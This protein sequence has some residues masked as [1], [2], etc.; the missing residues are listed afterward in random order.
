MKPMMNKRVDEIFTDCYIAMSDNVRRDMAN[1]FD[2]VGNIGLRHKRAV[3]K[4]DPGGVYLLLK[5]GEVKP[6]K[7]QENLLTKFAHR[8][9]T[10]PVPSPTHL[11]RVNSRKMSTSAHNSVPS[12][13]RARI[14]Q[15]SKTRASSP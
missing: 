6:Q 9:E 5:M 12:S 2:K 7:E 15:P 8:V 10:E 14:I 3:S 11:A 1:F 13:H 4:A